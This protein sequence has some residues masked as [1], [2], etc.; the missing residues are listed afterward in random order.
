MAER[1]QWEEALDM[2]QRARLLL[3]RSDSRR[4]V[5][6]LYVAYAFLCLEA[7]PPRIREVCEA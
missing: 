5:S 2:A 7:E 6:R 1:R 4:E 3:E